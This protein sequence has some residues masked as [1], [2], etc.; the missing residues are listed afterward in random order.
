MIFNAD[1]D[2]NMRD[3]SGKKPMQYLVRQDASMSLDTFK[4]EIFVI[5][6]TPRTLQNRSHSTASN[7][8]SYNT[9]RLSADMSIKVS[10]PTCNDN[11]SSLN[12]PLYP[13]DPKIPSTS[14]SP[15]N[16]VSSLSS[17]VQL[18]S[19][20]SFRKKPSNS[21]SDL[22]ND[23]FLSVKSSREF[24]PSLK[25]SKSGSPT[26]TSSLHGSTTSLRSNASFAGLS[27]AKNSNAFHSGGGIR[28]SFRRGIR[29]LMENSTP[30]NKKAAAA[31]KDP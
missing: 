25:L 8:S 18:L 24:L 10:L 28:S 15:K 21:S 1:A 16:R 17:P 6:R 27:V 7:F 29:N 14:I 2:A 9:T 11:S 4:S 3:H 23:G 26:P 30:K 20:S 22:K 12:A 13:T 31:L 19:F 5:P